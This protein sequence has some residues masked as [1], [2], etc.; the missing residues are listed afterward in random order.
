MTEDVVLGTINITV[1]LPA[2]GSELEVSTG[3]DGH[4]D[5]MTQLGALEMARQSL[6]DLNDSSSEGE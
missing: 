4:I 5:L 6:W 2:N 1:H 3:V